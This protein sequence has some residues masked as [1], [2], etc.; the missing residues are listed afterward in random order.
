MD[1]QT[2]RKN[3]KTSLAMINIKFMILFEKGGR[4]NGFG[5]I[6]RPQLYL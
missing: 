1:T 6:H 2:C 3:M 4:R 5:R